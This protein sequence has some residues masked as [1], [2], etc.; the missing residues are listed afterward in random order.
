[1]GNFM[2]EAGI[3]NFVRINASNGQLGDISFTSK[4]R[5][6][7]TYYTNGKPPIFD[8]RRVNQIVWEELP[9]KHSAID[10]AIGQI[11]SNIKKNP[12]H[13]GE[14][15]NLAGYSYGSVLQAQVALRLANE[16]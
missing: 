4:Y 11:R 13:K 10:V 14:Q 6:S 16:G 3:K 8:T 5:S 9:I 15:F 1:W 7:G 2:T 12:L